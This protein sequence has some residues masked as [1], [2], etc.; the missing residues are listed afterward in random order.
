MWCE[1]LS[2]VVIIYLSVANYQL[3][4]GQI[5]TVSIKN[6][7]EKKNKNKIQWCDFVQEIIIHTRFNS[8]QTQSRC[9]SGDFSLL[10][11]FVVFHL[12]FDHQL[13]ITNKLFIRLCSK[14]CSCKSFNW[15]GINNALEHTHTHTRKI[16]WERIFRV[17]F[18]GAVFF[19][20][21]VSNGRQS[22]SEAIQHTL[23]CQHR[24]YACLFDRSPVRN[25][26]SKIIVFRGKSI[27]LSSFTLS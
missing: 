26:F 27:I 23:A 22:V 7:R 3:Q 16:D 25:K 20:F 8:V 11:V 12:T 10:L 19:L 6:L 15:S 18:Y 14:R 4:V 9:V 1:T 17:P 2:L 24:V 5:S 13:S 21:C